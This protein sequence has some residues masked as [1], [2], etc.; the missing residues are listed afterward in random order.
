[1]LVGQMQLTCLSTVSDCHQDS[2]FSWCQIFPR[3]WT[4][5]YLQGCS[6]LNSQQ[7][8]T[9]LLQV[10]EVDAIAAGSFK[11]LEPPDIKASGYVVRS[12]EAVLWA[13]YHT[14][15][16]KDGCLKVGKDFYGGITQLPL[17]NFFVL[18]V[19]LGDD[20][21]TVGAIYGQLAGAYYG[22]D[23]IPEDWRRKCSLTPLLKLFG[24]ELLSLSASIPVPDNAAYKAM[25]WSASF[26]PVERQK[27][28]ENH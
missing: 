17:L 19:N 16:F 3:F 10:P 6:Q 21:D 23:A 8:Y 1:M 26:L 13:F 11:T 2:S 18:L 4:D 27:C 20:A 5:D 22:A 25:D 15:N 24:S 12:L 14:Q 9:F 7:S 28:E